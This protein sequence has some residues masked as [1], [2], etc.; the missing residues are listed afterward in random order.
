MKERVTVATGE[1]GCLVADTLHADL[2][3]DAN[4]STT[5]EWA[6][7]KVFRGV[8]EGDITRYAIAKKEPLLSEHE[9]F[10]DAVLGRDADLVT[11]WEAACTV[12]VAEAVLTSAASG[13]TVAPTVPRLD[14]SGTTAA[15]EP[16]RCER[17]RS[18]GG[19][20]M[21]ED[22]VTA[23]AL[24]KVYPGAPGPTVD[25]MTFSVPAGQSVGLL[26]P[27]APGRPPC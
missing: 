16:P 20:A 2:T 21:T 14:G 24:T 19:S 27:N 10:R 3:Y 18:A 13:Q 1:R 12:A 22:A 23:T 11:L 26:G 25:R 15:A 6:A 4:G 9:T 5:T 8:T 17:C 7:A